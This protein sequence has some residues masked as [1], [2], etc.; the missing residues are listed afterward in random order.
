MTESIDVPKYIPNKNATDI[1]IVE[2]IITQIEFIISDVQLYD[3]ERT[4]GELGH[5]TKNSSQL[6]NFSDWELKQ[7]TEHFELLLRTAKLERLFCSLDLIVRLFE[8]DLAV[9]MMKYHKDISL[10]LFDENCQPLVVAAFKMNLYKL[11][12]ILVKSTMKIFSNI[13]AFD[14]PEFTKDVFG[15]SIQR[16]CMFGGLLNFFST[17]SHHSSIGSG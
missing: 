6:L 4:A 5:D 17:A 14:Y 8:A 15:V 16:R 10:N 7:E 12:S 2:F 11:S 9:F 1:S 3:K 13:V